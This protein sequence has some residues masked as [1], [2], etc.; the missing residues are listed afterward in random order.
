[1]KLLLDEMFPP[2]VARALRERG[3]DA[4]AVAERPELVA[5]GDRELFEVAQHDGRVI[6]TENVADFAG[7]D[8]RYREDGKDHCGLMFVL[9]DGLPRKRAQ[10]VGAM[11]RKLDTWL[12]EHP[13]SGIP[14]LIAWP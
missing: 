9:K 1:V 11:T 3:H 12:T 6:V 2:D 10:F 13:D 4:I 8:A 14:G 7:I 5:L